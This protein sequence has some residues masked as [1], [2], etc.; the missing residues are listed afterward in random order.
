MDPNATLDLL[1]SAL[2]SGNHARATEHA[3]NLA[4]WV[5]GGGFEPD[6]PNWRAYVRQALH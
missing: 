5:A 6:N 1:I 4:D 3:R 2:N